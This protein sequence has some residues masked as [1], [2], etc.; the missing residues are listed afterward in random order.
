MIRLTLAIFA[1]AVMSTAA[2]SQVRPDATAVLARDAEN[3]VEMW[4]GRFD[5]A[6]QVNF[7]ER[8]NLPEEGWVARHHKIFARVDLPAFGPTVTYVEQYA[9]SPPDILVRQRLY[10]HRVD[11]G[12]LKT[13]IYA[14]RG[15]DAEKAGG[16]HEDPSKLDGLTPDTM[17]KLPD[18]CAIIWQA[19][20]DMFLGTQTPDECLYTPEGFGMEVRLRDTITL[21][22]DSMTTQTEILDAKG[23]VLMANELGVAE[24]ARKA[25]PFTCMMLARNPDNEKGFERYAGIRTH[26]QGG[27]YEVKTQHSP[28]KELHVRLLNIVPPA[29]TSRNTFIMTLTE[30]NDL[31][32]LARAFVAPD[33]E[34]VAIS[35]AGIEAN[36]TAD[37]GEAARF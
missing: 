32:P 23:E 10:V 33:A 2:Q 34:R 21:T 7:Q 13:D 25:R 1:A 35:I 17:S 11:A 18:G 8:F 15:D 3:L 12:A 29:G 9:G 27:E 26:D 16:A 14:F 37:T 5:T 4:Q 24:V 19:R 36:C 28:P 22:A 20:G 30:K 31:F 6:N